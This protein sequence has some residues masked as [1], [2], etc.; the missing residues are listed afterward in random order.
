[1]RRI[2][3][4]KNN[5]KEIEDNINYDIV[6]YKQ[7]FEINDKA[8]EFGVVEDIN[9]EVFKAVLF[10][11]EHRDVVRGGDLDC[12]DFVVFEDI[13]NNQQKLIWEACDEDLNSGW[14]Y[15]STMCDI[16]NK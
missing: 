11:V 12:Y 3:G 7:N 2:K 14:T 16:L 6:K 1:G 15:Q 9:N 10:R 8:I 13:L 4:V 5:G